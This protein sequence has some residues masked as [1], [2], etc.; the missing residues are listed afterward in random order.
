MD[1][2]VLRGGIPLSECSLWLERRRSADEEIVDQA[3]DHAT[4]VRRLAAVDSLSLDWNE[5][6]AKSARQYLE[7]TGFSC[8]V[9]LSNSHRML[10][11]VIRQGRQ[12]TA[13]VRRAPAEGGTNV[14]FGS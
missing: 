4:F 11:A 7:M 9:S 1:R 5:N 2:G 6:A 13:R 3:F 8:K 10:E 12:P 14:C